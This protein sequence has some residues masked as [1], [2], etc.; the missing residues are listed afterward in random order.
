MKRLIIIT[1]SIAAICC[2]DEMQY[3]FII[4]N[5][6]IN[7]IVVKFKAHYENDKN[8]TISPGIQ[9]TIFIF[10]IIEGMK[11]HERRINN[12]FSYIEI[13]SD[14]VLSKNDFL[15]N[16]MWTYSKKSDTHA[17]YFLRV[18]SLNFH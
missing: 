9:D 11:I 3:D 13:Y 5:Q 17:V 2:D 12:I 18:D 7:E 14:T 8:L 6:T 15:S 1:L 16:D 10:T 4:E